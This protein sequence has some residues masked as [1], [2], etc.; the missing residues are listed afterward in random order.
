[1]IIPANSSLSTF[2]RI[3]VGVY[4]LNIV[5]LSYITNSN[6]L[7]APILPWDC[8]H[9]ERRETYSLQETSS[10]ILETFINNPFEFLITYKINNRKNISN[11]LNKQVDKQGRAATESKRLRIFKCQYRKLRK[12]ATYNDWWEPQKTRN[13]RLKRDTRRKRKKKKTEAIE[14]L[15]FICEINRFQK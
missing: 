10:L 4:R 2:V 5:L 11:H 1:M 9:R 15:N 13:K 3:T 8:T 7:K 12:T 6:L 14:R